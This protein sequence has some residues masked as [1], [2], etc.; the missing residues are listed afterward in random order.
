MNKCICC[1]QEVEYIEMFGACVKCSYEILEM[2][3]SHHM[4]LDNS[5][6][7]SIMPKSCEPSGCCNF[8]L[9]S[10]SFKNDEKLP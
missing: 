2:N 5:W 9:I 3:K 8:S 7:I 10:D 1:G 6:K 4:R